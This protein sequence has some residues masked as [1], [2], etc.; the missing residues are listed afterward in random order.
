MLLGS[1]NYKSYTNPQGILIGIRASLRPLTYHAKC[2]ACGCEFRTSHVRVETC[3]CP[4]HCKTRTTQKPSPTARAGTGIREESVRSSQSAESAAF[5]DQEEDTGE[6][7]STG[8]R[9]R[10]YSASKGLSGYFE[11]PTF[12]ND[13]DRASYREFKHEFD[14]EKERPLKEATEA[15]K[16]SA[17]AVARARRQFVAESVDPEFYITPDEWDNLNAASELALGGSDEALGFLN[18]SVIEKFRVFGSHHDFVNSPKN[19]D[20]LTAYC[21]RNMHAHGIKS[22]VYVPFEILVRA[23][24]RLRLFSLLEEPTHVYIDPEP[25]K[26]NYFETEQRRQREEEQRQAEKATRRGV[27]PQTGAERI[28]STREVRLMSAD[29]FKRCFF[30]KIAPTFKDLFIAL[31]ENRTGAQT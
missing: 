3:S 17:D 27:D 28:Y 13:R 20:A 16:K 4:M 7:N 1:Q 2:S 14:E 12:N 29:Q 22:V 31:S 25:D 18:Q 8:N 11:S 26:E 21:E 5:R 30:S 9:N 10:R 6:V 24:A 19:L 15:F 23:F